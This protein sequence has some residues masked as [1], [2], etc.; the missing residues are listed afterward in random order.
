MRLNRF[1]LNQIVCL[2]ALIAERSVSRAAE[3]RRDRDDKER[4]ELSAG[5]A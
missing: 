1:D 4:A 5:P 3:R 2:E